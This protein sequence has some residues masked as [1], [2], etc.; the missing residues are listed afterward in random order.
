MVLLKIQ[1]VTK[2]SIGHDF[3]MDIQIDNRQKLD[4]ER[5]RYRDR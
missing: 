1:V 2:Q 5:E 4:R 3:T